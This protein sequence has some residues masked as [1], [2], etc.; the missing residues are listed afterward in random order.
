MPERESRQARRLVSEKHP[1]GEE[2]GAAPGQTGEAQRPEAVEENRWTALRIMLIVC[3]LIAV[4]LGAL[5][6]FLPLLPT[7]PF[8]LVAAWCFARSSRRFHRWLERH[9][10]FGPLLANWREHGAIARRVKVIAL[11]TLVASSA[12]GWALSLSPLALAIQ[13]LALLLVG[14]FIWSRPEPP[15]RPEGTAETRSEAS[16]A[17]EAHGDP[18]DDVG[19][20]TGDSWR[21]DREGLGSQKKREEGAR[22]ADS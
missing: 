14:V 5:G 3:G 15:R 1:P 2:A 10:R 13:H 20:E 17:N 4:G 21:R 16:A 12:L 7:T 8:V 11:L 22:D 6:I 18:L 9:P 19:A